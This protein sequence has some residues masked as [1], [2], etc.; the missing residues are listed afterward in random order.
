MSADGKVPEPEKHAAPGNDLGFALPEPARV[1]HTRALAIGAAAVVV[2][3]GAFLAAYLPKRQARAALEIDARSEQ[4]ARLRVDVVTPKVLASERPMI[5]PGSVQPFEETTVYSRANGYVRRWH[6]DIG[7]KV[8]EGQ[9]LAELDTPELDQELAQAQAQLAQARAGVALAQANRDFSRANLER[10]RK[11][12]PEGVASQQDLDQKKQQ[13]AVDEAAV[14]VAQAAVG[15]QQANLMR[16]TQLKSFARVTAPFGGSVTSR[17]IERGALVTA[18]SATP[19]FK[20]A[21]TDPVR[22]VIQVPQDLAPS[23]RAE[24]PAKVTVREH[25]GR[26]FEGKVARFSGALDPASR[27]MTTEVRVP[28]PKGELLAGMYAEVALSLPA[29]HR[30]F[31]LPGTAIQ[32][33]AHG[34]RVAV[35]DAKNELRL[36]PVVIERDTGSTVFISSGL[37]GTERVVKIAGT[38]LV[39]GRPVDVTK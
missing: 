37:E 36:V 7:D 5:L 12:A 1:S 27:T 11:M 15:S 16:L 26:A 33:D 3:G 38:E 8:E 20:I 4:Q 21:A 25:A 30:V 6:A 24:V 19:L 10:Y 32:N 9:L 31:E 18:G 28:N 14:T 34:V 22:V 35:V 23:V 13:A 2:L 39:D 17:S 29:P